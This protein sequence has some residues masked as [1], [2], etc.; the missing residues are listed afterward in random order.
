MEITQAN[1]K[2]TEYAICEVCGTK[3]KKC[4]SY[5]EPYYD[6]MGKLFNMPKTDRTDPYGGHREKIIYVPHSRGFYHIGFPLCAPCHS[7]VACNN[8]ERSVYESRSEFHKYID[9][10]SRYRAWC[11][12][13]TSTKSGTVTTNTMLYSIMN[14]PFKKGL[15][16]KI[17]CSDDP[18]TKDNV[19]KSSKLKNVMVTNLYPKKTI[20]EW[21]VNTDHS[22]QSEPYCEFI[23]YRDGDKKKGNEWHDEFH[24]FVDVIP[25][26][27]V[28]NRAVETI[29][30]WW[31]RVRAPSHHLSEINEKI[32]TELP[33][34]L[35]MLEEQKLQII[36]KISEQ[37]RKKYV[38]EATVK[39]IEKEKKE[40]QCQ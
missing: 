40:K 29:I 7:I 15:V 1:I 24:C 9:E 8:S 4:K 19:R 21:A 14:K 33:E 5:K 26:E 27:E 39:R 32:N 37:K 20:P 25:Y 35:K 38:L 11:R 12:I 30:K 31:K 36:K 34:Q 18:S 17:P 22:G 2:P 23:A 28:K 3:G 6:C 13:S 16:V 10:R